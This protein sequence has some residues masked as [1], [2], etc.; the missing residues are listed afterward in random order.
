MSSALSN[1]VK[2]R[3]NIVLSILPKELNQ[4]FISTFKIL[5]FKLHIYTVCVEVVLVVV[6][7]EIEVVKVVD[8]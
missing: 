4:S 6:V 5:K 1:F 3:F 7:F 8:K 2:C